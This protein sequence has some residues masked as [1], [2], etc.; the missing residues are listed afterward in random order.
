MQEMP[1]AAAH[2][3]DR[4]RSREFVALLKDTNLTSHFR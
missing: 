3:E 4:H 1:Y 2:V